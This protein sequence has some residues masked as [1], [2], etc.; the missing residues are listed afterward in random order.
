MPEG[1]PKD[2]PPPLTPPVM[3]ISNPTVTLTPSAPYTV[4][5]G[6]DQ[7]RCFVLDPKITQTQ[8]ITAD[9]V[10]PGN[11]S[12]VH[13][14]VV[15]SDPMGQRKAKGGTSGQYDCFGGAGLTNSSLL[16]AFAPGGQPTTYP[17]GVAMPI[18][19]GTLS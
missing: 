5:N 3:G 11:K 19:P 14:V 10:L 15:F 17:E 13:H 4:A 18:R 12:V 2:A 8:Y 16:M 1:D 6:G 7:F 9:A